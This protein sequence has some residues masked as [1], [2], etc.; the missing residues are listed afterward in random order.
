MADPFDLERLRVDPADLQRKPKR[1]K[2][3]PALRAGPLGMGRATKSVS[4]SVAPIGSPYCWSTSI[5]VRA[6]GRSC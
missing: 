2:W 4:T 6:G 3:Q 1:K 5:G